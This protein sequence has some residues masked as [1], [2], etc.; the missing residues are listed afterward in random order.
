MGFEVL[1]CLDPIL[2]GKQSS[3]AR[4]SWPVLLRLHLFWA[5]WAVPRVAAHPA[6]GSEEPLT[7]GLSPRV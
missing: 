7:T 6:W 1:G 3:P 4:A 2:Y 5:Q